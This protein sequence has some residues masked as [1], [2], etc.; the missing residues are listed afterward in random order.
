MYQRIRLGFT[1]SYLIPGDKGY[2]LIDAGGPGKTRTFL[3]KIKKKGISP[4]QIAL[5]VITHAHFDHAGSLFQ[6]RERCNCP[7]AVHAIE[8]D[9]LRDAKVVIPPGTKWLNKQLSKI[10][11]NNPKVISRLFRF[12]AVSPDI[13]ANRN[14]SLKSYGF[15]ADIIPTP[16]HTSGSLSVVTESGA[17]FTG[18]LAVNYYPF[19]SGPY[20]PP[21]G[22][23]E[24]VILE[25]WKK[26]LGLG[27]S[28][29]YPAH[30]KPFN[31]NK[32]KQILEKGASQ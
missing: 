30:G 23:S 10:A 15:Q 16:G 27:V 19:G 18:D 14:V 21:F 3:R 12:R 20:F 11:W 22:D 25:S 28:T 17:A 8:A 4:E 32:L 5:I 31:A 13:L 2:L 6:I 26:L 9:I 29:I 7:I 24:A 1:N